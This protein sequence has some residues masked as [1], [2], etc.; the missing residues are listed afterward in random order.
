MTLPGSGVPGTTLSVV[1]LLGPKLPDSKPVDLGGLLCEAAETVLAAEGVRSVGRL[2]PCSFCFFRYCSC[3]VA[4]WLK[5]GGVATV[6]WYRVLR[7]GGGVG[8]LIDPLE[9]LYMLPVL[10]G[11]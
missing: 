7:G 5:G 2:G 8:R 3:C 1:S 9:I 6:L 11:E 10:S 4:V